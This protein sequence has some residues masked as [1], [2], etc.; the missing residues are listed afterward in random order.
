MPH[1]TLLKIIAYAIGLM[2][3]WYGWKIISGV[4]PYGEEL[5][6]GYVKIALGV[7]ILYVNVFKVPKRFGVL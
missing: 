7:V 3:L 2:S 1:I 4:N 5:W 6:M